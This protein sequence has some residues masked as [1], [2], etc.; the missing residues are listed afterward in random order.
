MKVVSFV[1]I[2]LLTACG[3]SG[4]Q[5]KAAPPA[6]KYDVLIYVYR[7]NTM[8]GIINFDVPFIHL[9]GNLLTRIRIGG[10]LARRV[11]PGRHTLSTTESLFG[12][13]TGKVR[14]ETIFEAGPGA[15]V[16]LRYTEHF[17]TITPIILPNAVFISSTGDFR[18]E[19]VD[20]PTALQ[21]LAET[22][23]LT[24]RD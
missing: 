22:E 9:D 12:R 23:Q 5:F 15:T 24:G 2:L 13:D 21:E 18:F 3:A 10:Y 6:S 4:P 16:Y 19:M 11:A 7:P 20:E 1:L 8:I 14:G 17:K